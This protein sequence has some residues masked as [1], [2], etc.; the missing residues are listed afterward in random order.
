M[1]AIPTGAKGRFTLVTAPEH[2]ANRLKDPSLPPVLATPVMI[3]M[4]ENAAFNA[5][6]EFLEPGESAVGTMVDVRHLAPTPVGQTVTAEAEVTQVEGQRIAFTVTAH[7]G[8]EQIGAGLHER[9]VVDLQRLAK[10]L[11]AKNNRV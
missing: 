11:A 2:L 3:L 5:I 4:M 7:D 8:M 10:R 1:H 9:A 6:R